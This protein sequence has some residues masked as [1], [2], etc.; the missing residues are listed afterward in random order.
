[1]LTSVLS[2][3]NNSTLAQHLLIFLRNNLG[4]ICYMSTIS[5]DRVGRGWLRQAGI[6]CDH[7]S[8]LKLSFQSHR[9]FCLLGQL[10]YTIVSILI[11]FYGCFRNLARFHFHSWINTPGTT[12]LAPLNCLCSH[13]SVTSVS[14]LVF[15]SQVLFLSNHSLQ[16]R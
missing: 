5:L 2:F 14:Y 10:I 15:L 1:M 8:L 13:H 4:I 6:P 16:C 9:M 3:F 12:K 11:H 7:N